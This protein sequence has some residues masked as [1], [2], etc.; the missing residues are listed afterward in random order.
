MKRGGAVRATISS[1]STGHAA[2]GRISALEQRVG[3]NDAESPPGRKAGINAQGIRANTEHPG[4]ASV[5]GERS[6]AACDG[7]G[8]PPATSARVGPRR[9][10]RRAMFK[11]LHTST[12]LLILCGLFILSLGVATYQL[13]VEKQI[14]IDFARKELVGDRYVSALDE[15]YVALMIGPPSSQSTEQR[16]NSGA[17]IVDAL[18][19]AEADAGKVLH[20]AEIETALAA[21]LAELWSSKADRDLDRLTL[22]ALT[23]ARNLAT[24]IGDD[25]NLTLD[26]DLDTYYLQDVVVVDLPTLLGELAELQLLFRRDGA[27]DAPSSERSVR[28]LVADGLLRSTIEEMQG[29]LATAYYGNAD[30]SLK[31]AIDTAFTVMFS[32]S[33]SHLER[34][35]AGSLNGEAKGS[36]LGSIDRTYADAVR[37]AI[38]A[39]ANAQTELDRL[40]KQRIGHLIGKLNGSLALIGALA[41]LCLLLSAMTYQHIARP[42]ARFESLVK[43]VRETKN[44]NLRIDHESNDEIGKLVAAFNDMLSELA[45]VRAQESSDH[46]E[47]GRVARL[48]MMGAMTASIAHEINQPLAAIAANASAALRWL[49]RTTPEVDEAGAALRQIVGDAHGASQVIESIRS[50]FK[51]DNREKDFIGVNDLVR[52]VLILAHGRLKS[53][54]ISV[55]VELHE[56][57][58]HVL[59]DRVQLQQVLLNLIM[60]GIDAMASIRDRARSL[61][62][63]S[64]LQPPCDVL[65]SVQDVGSGIDLEDMGRIFDAF[66]TTKSNGMGMGLFIC[67]TIIEAHG[68]RLWASAGAPHGSNFHITLPVAGAGGK[69]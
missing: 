51:K 30:G 34:L 4:T 46:L 24:R 11:N 36:E 12:K 2:L 3:C 6:V 60:N 56:D 68:G 23:K 5:W 38:D 61:V 15:I 54:Q 52:G 69:S 55:E 16:N 64:E 49:T 65:I 1:V 18:A 32:A 45:T 62:I 59:A 41:C 29:H 50:I 20:T 14:A 22:E 13:I 27:A 8:G 26:P 17:Q 19:L 43:K 31:R 25:S 35:R 67:R 10:S 40:L 9:P 44:Y 57:L 48:T 28:I 7:L 58:P 66:F 33:I 63:K 47:F 42:L 53:Q 21:R 39:W 37:R